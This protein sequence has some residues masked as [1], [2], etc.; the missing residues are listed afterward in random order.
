[1]FRKAVNSMWNMLNNTCLRLSLDCLPSWH[2]L[3]VIGASGAVL[4]CFISWLRNSRCFVQHRNNIRTLKTIKRDVMNFMDLQWPTLDL[5]RF[6]AC[7]CFIISCT[8]RETL[9]QSPASGSGT[10]NY[11]YNFLSHQSVLD[12]LFNLFW[13]SLK[14]ES[15]DRT[16]ADENW[17]LLLRSSA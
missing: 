6:E 12:D 8:R 10:S 14:L 13:L 9:F 4:T 3:T 15:K 16:V 2:I 7:T 11:N 17:N 5:H 1:M